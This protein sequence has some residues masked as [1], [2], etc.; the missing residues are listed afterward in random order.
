[1]AEMTIRRFGILS[2]AKMQ[3]LLM[4]VI[5]L[6]I[7]VIYGLLFMLFGAAVA[8]LAPQSESQA[9]GGLGSV[10]GGLVIII[11]MPIFYGL[12]GFIGGAIAAI[13]YNIAA[14]VVG[15]IRFELEGAAPVYAPPPSPHQWAPNQYQ[16]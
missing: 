3:A 5:G 7:G 10:V 11:A 16:A 2:V 8:A 4:F 9:W 13:I 6:I 15:G 1:M 12:I 14:G